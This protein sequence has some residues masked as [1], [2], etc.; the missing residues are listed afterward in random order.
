[1]WHLTLAFHGDRADQDEQVERLRRLRG[2]AAPELAL[3]DAGTFRSGVFW[4][5]VQCSDDALER[6]AIAA[7]ADP[8]RWRPHLTVARRARGARLDGYTGR[9]WTPPQVELVRSELGPGG[10]VYRTVESAPLSTSND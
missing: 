9:L 4:I 10:P 1:L 3:G 2:M 8:Q 7:G 5:G 6:L